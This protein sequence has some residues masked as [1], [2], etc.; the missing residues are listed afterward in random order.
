MGSCPLMYKVPQRGT[1]SVFA[2]SDV[3]RGN[4]VH[5]P[6]NSKRVPP[7]GQQEHKSLKVSAND[8]K[9]ESSSHKELG[10][11]LDPLGTHIP[12]RMI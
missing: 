2:M 10:M 11:T 6:I 1:A 8:K 12:K 9:G 3:G 5:K 4:R 7:K